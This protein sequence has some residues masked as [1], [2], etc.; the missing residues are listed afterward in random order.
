M[1]TKAWVILLLAAIGLPGEV[2]GRDGA[3]DEPFGCV[4]PEVLYDMLNLAE[5]LSAASRGRLSAKSC[6]SLVGAR[7][8]V[9]GEGDGLAKIRIFAKP[10]DWAT[11][12][13][14]FTLDEMLDPDGMLDPSALAHQ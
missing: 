5:P 3:M 6:V 4:N 10:G 2:H 11:S 14:V 9:V 8:L 1:M 12:A 7:Y 13:V